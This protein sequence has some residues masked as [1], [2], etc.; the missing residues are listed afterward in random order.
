MI[1]IPRRPLPKRFAG[2]LNF[3]RRKNIGVQIKCLAETCR[4]FFPS[5]LQQRHYNKRT[6][7]VMIDTVGHV[8]Y[9]EQD[10][11][12]GS[13]NPNGIT[14]LD[15]N[16]G[17]YN[18]YYE[19]MNYMVGLLTHE[20]MHLVIYAIEDHKMAYNH[21]GC[22]DRVDHPSIYDISFIEYDQNL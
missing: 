3:D 11:K 18:D 9:F 4:E 10:I 17:S 16:L 8:D 13:E 21:A 7:F 2:Y 22:L 19:D 5:R 6:D 14:I 1:T 15:D 20:T 12:I